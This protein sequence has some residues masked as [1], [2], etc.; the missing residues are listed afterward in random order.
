[1]S[2]ATLRVGPSVQNRDAKRIHTWTGIR[3]HAG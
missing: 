2:G 3:V 1:M